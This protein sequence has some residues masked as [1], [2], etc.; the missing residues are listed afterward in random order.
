MYGL[1]L[2]VARISCRYTCIHALV[3]DIV[4]LESMIKIGAV[5]FK[6]FVPG[7]MRSMRVSKF[8][9]S[10]CALEANRKVFFDID[11][12]G[13]N[14]GRIVFDLYTD[15]TPK[16][17]E[18]FRALCTGEK[19]FGFKGNRFHRIIPKFMCQGGDITVRITKI[20]Y[21]NLLS[22]ATLAR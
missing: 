18:N 7:V 5:S 10:V 6:S 11:I 4:V 2:C 13:K 14:A 8:H 1:H 20:S 15:I 21:L 12:A 19:G 22:G 16:T 9:Q 17:A 3:R